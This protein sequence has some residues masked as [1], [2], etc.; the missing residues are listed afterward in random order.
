MVRGSLSLFLVLTD[1]AA[2]YY[3]SFQERTAP[4]PI[5]ALNDQAKFRSLDR[6]PVTKLIE[7][8]IVQ[9]IARLSKATGI[10]VSTVNPGLCRTEIGRDTGIFLRVIYGW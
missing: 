8:F 10:I 5:S 6:Y 1:S 2:H 9:K 7:I 3:A 4:K